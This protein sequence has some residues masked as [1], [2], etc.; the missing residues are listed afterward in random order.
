VDPVRRR[1]LRA[2]EEIH[3][4]PK[5]FD[6]LLVLVQSEGD[7]V[8]KDE[9]MEAVWPDTAVE[10]NNLT[11]NISVLR[12]TF[13]ERPDDHRYIVTVPGQGYRFV[14]AIAESAGE[15][16]DL[17]VARYTKSRV[18]VEDELTITPERSQTAPVAG[19]SG[20]SERSTKNGMPLSSAVLIAGLLTTVLS[21]LTYFAFRD[22]SKQQPALD[23]ARKIAVLPFR[24]LS[25]AGDDEYLGLGI[26]DTLI[27]RLSNVRQIMV[28]P[29]NAVRK[30]AGREFDPLAAG[31]EQQVHAVLEGSVERAG[32]RLRVT[33]RL[34]S[35]EDGR[36]VWGETFDEEFTDI[37]TVQDLIAVRLTDALAVRLTGEEKRNLAKQYTLNTEAYQLYLKGRYFW[38]KRTTEDLKRS[39]VYFTQ[40]VEKDPRFALA[41]AGLADSYSLLT[42]YEEIPAGETYPQAKMAV[43][44]ALGIDGELAEARTSLAYIK[45]FYEWDWASAEMEFKRAI[46]LNPNYATAHQWYAEHLSAMGRTNEALAEIKRAEELDPVSLIIGAVEAWIL[47]FARD[48]DG[49]IAKCLKVI[50]MDPKFAEAYEYLKRSYDQK[51]M[52]RE[53]ISARQTR[54]KILGRET[55]DNAALR[56]AASATSSRV[57]WQKRLELE[58]EE[59]KQD[60]LSA[61]EMAEILA[62]VGEKDRALDW[63]VKAHAQ[64]HF[65][66]MYL[67]V[68]PNL[69]PL[70]SDP[71]FAD[72]VG[73]VGLSQ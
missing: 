63:L 18:I 35:I 33:V 65:M 13:G 40:A 48:F 23:R 68:A 38:N 8:T 51:G 20:I 55:R 25:A 37:L 52:Y 31:R 53:A 17:T 9:L 32:D 5:V 50:D 71:R 49:A 14:A 21:G 16:E 64:H 10:E 30:Y 22:G 27:T 12:K 45:A 3:L 2:D 24:S 61:F 43:T 34:I 46:E 26:S 28:R 41:Y 58:I 60:Q 1:L 69:D 11:Q 70:R 73:R 62:Q 19:S 15:R 7:L 59:S 54:R 67:K 57:Y 66:I 42:D 72:L 56:V 47:Y 6:T 29:T 36:P 39:V 44:K 4:K